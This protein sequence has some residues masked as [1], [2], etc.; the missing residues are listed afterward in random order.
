M[1]TLRKSR[2]TPYYSLDI[3]HQVEV[4]YQKKNES[5]VARYRRHHHHHNAIMTQRQPTTRRCCGFQYPSVKM[6]GGRHINVAANDSMAGR[7]THTHTSRSYKY[8]SE[9]RKKKPTPD[10]WPEHNDRSLLSLYFALTLR[11]YAITEHN[12]YPTWHAHFVSVR[13]LRHSAQ[14]IYETQSRRRAVL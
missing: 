13:R 5:I 14:C 4:S 6:M 2:P 11:K 10:R 7:Q 1:Y 12:E 8:V 9:Q 3:T